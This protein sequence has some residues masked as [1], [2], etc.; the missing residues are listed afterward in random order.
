M[1]LKSTAG[2]YGEAAKGRGATINPEGRFESLSRDTVEDGWFQEPEESASKPKTVIAIEHAKSVI[3]RHD[4]PDVGFSQSIN[5]YRGCAHGCSYCI[6][7]DTPI[8][9]ADG[10]TRPL[11]EVRVDDEIY[12]TKRIGP[13]RRY[14]KSRVLAHWS[15]IKPAY[16]ITLED[17]TTLVSSGDHRFLSDRGWKHVTGTECGASRRPHLTTSNKLMGT[18]SF[19]E[20]PLENDDYRRGYLCGVIRGDAHLATSIQLRSGGRASERHQFRLALCDP[21]ALLRAQDYL[22]DFEI[23]TYEFQFQAAVGNRRTLHAIRSQSMPKVGAIRALIAWPSNPSREWSL[24]FLAGIFDAEGC[25]SQTVL[26]I[27]NTDREIIDWISRSLK[28]FAFRFVIEHPH[29]E[30]ARKPI[31]VVRLVGGLREHL[32]FFHTVR[33]AITRKLDLTGQAIKS[34]ARL[35]VVSIE[36]LGKAMRLYDITTETEDFIANGVVSH[37]CFARPSHA[38]LGLSPGIDFETRL[39]AK[40]NAAEKLR[41]ELAKPG[42]RC[43]PL[44]IGVN[45]DAY[46]PIEREYRITRAIV[47][48]ASETRHPVSLITKSALVERDIDLLAPMAKDKLVSV[49]L[50]VTTLDAGI[51]RHMEP[52]TSAPARRL[53]AIERLSRAGIP[54]N[55]NVSPVIP[56]LTDSELEPIL[57]AAVKAGATSAGYNLVRLPWEV[58]DIFRA[59]LEAHFPLKAA[60]VMSRIHEMRGGRD[61]DPNFGTRM[62]GQGLFAQLLAQ[63]FEKAT[64]RLG[65]NDESGFELDCSL[66]RPPSL[67][68]QQSLF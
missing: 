52:R 12:G 31:D 61:N 5:P 29:R 28:T 9:M 22:L 64:R 30:V 58:K 43:E 17:G 45:T 35:R 10:R 49:T 36:S 21:E 16:R 60:H 51:S 26:R 53:L 40:T 47:E 6:S 27:S 14:V 4:S 38:Y 57:E 19:A 65:L 41:E 23:A 8:L 42:Y 25:F 1:P 7:G 56:F 33:P 39:S 15:S 3:S 67:G 44:T 2:N 55:V 62:T 59:W 20:G 50:S 54:V 32:R 13:Y 63:R 11:S 18:G 68:G 37:N 24:G 66:F 34:D 48:L 46:Q